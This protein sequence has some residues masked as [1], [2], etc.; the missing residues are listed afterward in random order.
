MTYLAAVRHCAARERLEAPVVRERD[1]AVPLEDERAR[2][3]REL[4]HGREQRDGACSWSGARETSV[5]EGVSPHFTLVLVV[6]EFRCWVSAGR[7]HRVLGFLLE[8][9]FQF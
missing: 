9:I 6:L 8:F 5:S 4:A 1:R 7:S 3:Q 2:Q